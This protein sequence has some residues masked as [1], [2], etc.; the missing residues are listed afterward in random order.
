[1]AGRKN[2]TTCDCNSCK[3]RKNVKLLAC[4][5]VLN[6]NYPPATSSISA[7]LSHSKATTEANASI[8]YCFIQR[9]AFTFMDNKVIKETNHG[10]PCRPLV[11]DT[12]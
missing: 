11:N 9:S 8:M 12:L 2:R 1:M 4:L 7:N 6:F 5:P 10:I 3:T